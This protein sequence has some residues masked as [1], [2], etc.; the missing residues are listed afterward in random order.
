MSASATTT[1]AA[2]NSKS[3]CDCGEDHQHHQQ[4]KNDA[5]KPHHTVKMRRPP[6]SMPP[7][8][9]LET[10][11]D[12][13]VPDE[14]SP[15]TERLDIKIDDQ[16]GDITCNKNGIVI[17]RKWVEG[18]GAVS[19]EESLRRRFKM[20]YFVERLGAFDAQFVIYVQREML[21]LRKSKSFCSFND[22]LEI[23]LKSKQ[24][25]NHAVIM[26]RLRALIHLTNNGSASAQV[27]TFCN[28]DV[29]LISRQQYITMLFT[30]L[31]WAFGGGERM[32]VFN[33]TL[34]SDISVM[35]YGQHLWFL[36]HYCIPSFNWYFRK[37]FSQ[38]L[39]EADKA[40][41]HA[42]QY[43]G[44][45]ELAIVIW[46]ALA[47]YMRTTLEALDLFLMPKL[48]K[49]GK[50]F[51][52]L[53]NEFHKRAAGSPVTTAER[54]KFMHNV[55]SGYLVKEVPS[56]MLGKKLDDF[57]PKA[58][59]LKISALA[60]YMCKSMLEFEIVNSEKFTESIKK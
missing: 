13:P 22:V 10:E 12:L 41:A 25:E 23:F 31:A 6:F 26:P 18:H 50:K 36:L 40:V 17:S 38:C 3:S 1:P 16:N 60:L 43:R 32:L 21:A 5:E 29:S 49:G 48:V 19:H 37:T 8:Q 54:R 52:D 58:A 46:L 15:D 24:Y 2:A 55:A 53:V 57:E 27:A 47:H 44:G 39:C 59:D 7:F 30:F 20:A 45:E 42:Y 51:D 35:Y 14:M 9:C 4:Y 28:A 11:Y 34:V 33:S 56:V